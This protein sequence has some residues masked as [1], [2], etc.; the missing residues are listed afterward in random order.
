MADIWGKA[1]EFFQRTFLHT[2]WRR[3][4]YLEEACSGRLGPLRLPLE[5]LRLLYLLPHPSL[6]LRN[7][8]DCLARRQLQSQ[9]DCLPPLLRLEAHSSLG[10]PPL[11]GHNLAQVQ[12]GH[13][14]LAGLPQA[15]YSE[16][17]RPVVHF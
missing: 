2:L 3:V 11:Q 5:V 16:E 15:P 13:P 12:M 10:L 9:Q 14:C 6:D 7:L 4:R 17:Q 8:G 1:A